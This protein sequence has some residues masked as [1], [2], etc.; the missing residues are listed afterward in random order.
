MFFHCVSLE[1][2]LHFVFLTLLQGVIEK[3]F[4]SVILPWKLKDYF[5]K[6][7][8][9]GRGVRVRVYKKSVPEAGCVSLCL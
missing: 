9:K 6:G 4:Q 7:L 8:I 3:Q 5:D 1:W 2:N